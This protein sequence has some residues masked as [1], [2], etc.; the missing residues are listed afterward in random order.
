M[1][2]CTKKY[3]L[4]FSENTY[5]FHILPV[6][7]CGYCKRRCSGVYINVRLRVVSEQCGLYNTQLTT[8]NYVPNFSKVLFF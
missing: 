1:S 3:G 8:I 5:L 4:Q 7:S 6:Y 2:L